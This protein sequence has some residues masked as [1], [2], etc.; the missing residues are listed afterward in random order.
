MRRAFLMVGFNNWGKTM[1]IYNLFVNRR[2]LIGYGYRLRNDVGRR[3]T[4]ESHSNDD[5]G[6][7]RYIAKILERVQAAPQDA[8]DLISVLCPSRE[9]QNNACDILASHAF[10]PFDEIHLLLLRYKWD[11]HAELRIAYVEKF[12]RHCGDKRLKLNVIDEGSSDSDDKRRLRRC[13][14][15][16]GIISKTIAKN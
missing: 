2:F 6:G 12:F 7:E 13:T 16:H 5:F 8:Q 15:A 3:F 4:V 1:L 10:Q 9:P 14:Q 11:L